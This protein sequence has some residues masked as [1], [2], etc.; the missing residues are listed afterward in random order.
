LD[1]L[2]GWEKHGG[3]MTKEE[4]R[5]YSKGYQAGLNRTFNSYAVLE[6]NLLNIIDLL[7]AK[8][9]EKSKSP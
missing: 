2:S 9:D 5:Q 4:Q 3:V 6:N 7:R 8:L 1:S